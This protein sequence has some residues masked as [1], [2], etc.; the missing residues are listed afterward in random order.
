MAE[1]TKLT[2]K[3][4]IAVWAIV[5]GIALATC[6]ESD[7]QK[8]KKAAEFSALPFEKKV[9][10]LSSSITEVR[11]DDA[12]DALMVFYNKKAIWDGNNWAWNFFGT[13]KTVLSKVNTLDPSV[14]YK[15]VVFMVHYPTRDSL[16]NEGSALG[17]KA[18]Y[19]MST[20]EGAKWDKMWESDIADLAGELQFKRDGLSLAAEYCK[21]KKDTA[22][23]FC[24][25]VLMEMM[26]RH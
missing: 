10:S 16:G 4:A 18:F 21:D 8:R 12:H 1:K 26:K 7:E 20:L 9:M 17:M 15:R 22:Q 24:R 19:T 14:Q 6:G 13:A 11:G 25:K 5:I 23:I 3:V 2:T